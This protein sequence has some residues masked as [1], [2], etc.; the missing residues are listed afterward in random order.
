MEDKSLKLKSPVSDNV[1]FELLIS[2]GRTKDT[3]LPK[4]CRQKHYHSFLEIMWITEGTGIIE[5]EKSWSVIFATV[6]L[7]PS[8]V[9][10]PF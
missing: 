5:T 2:N 1:I 3:R 10:E 8:I 4:K 7:I 6:R 9:I